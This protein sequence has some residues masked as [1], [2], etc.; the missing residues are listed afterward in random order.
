[1]MWKN[2]IDED[3]RDPEGGWTFIET[4]IVIAII[5]ILTSSVGFMA[6]RYLDKAKNRNSEERYRESV[7]RPEHLPAR[8][9]EF[10]P[11]KIRD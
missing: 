6:F 9:R 4:I 11:P 5:M 3:K 10:F 1:M 7:P 8:L 2:R